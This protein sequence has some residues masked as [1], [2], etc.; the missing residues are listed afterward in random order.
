[1]LVTIAACAA[2]PRPPP[3]PPRKTHLGLDVAS[4]ALSNGLR[5]VLVHDPAA[6]DVH[7]TMRYAVGAAEE[8][9]ERAGIAHLVEHL[10]F[11]QVLG[12]RSIFA[13]L[14]D[15][16]TVFNA[17]TTFDATTYVT[18]A[19]AE[20]LGELLT[21]EAVRL[22]LRCTSIT[23][24]A[25]EREREVVIN[26][27]RQ[28][29]PASG[30]LE[31]VH[32]GV[33]LPG[34]P[35]RNPIE[36]EASLRAITRAEACAFAD[37][38]YGT[39][40]AVLVISSSAEPAALQAP[41]LKAF[42]HVAAREVTAQEAVPAPGPRRS[43]EVDAPIDE[44][45]I[46]LS[47]PMPADPGTQ[48]QLRA[49]V[50]L[51]AGELGD[52]LRGD[53]AAVVLGDVRSPRI[54]VVVAPG[55]GET[56]DVVGRSAQRALD[57]MTGLALL[58]RFALTRVLY[59]SVPQAAAY[60]L[61][62]SL[63]DA[64]S[65]DPLLAAFVLEGRDPETALGLQFRALNELTPQRAASLVHED[66]AYDRA[67]IVALRAVGKKRGRRTSFVPPIHDLGQR[68]EAPDPEVAHHPLA[69][70]RSP[71]PVQ[72]RRLPNGL[73]VVLVPSAAV[74]TVDIRL[75]LGVGSG[76]DRPDQRGLA[77]LAAS[78]LRWDDRYM[79]DRLLF[80]AAGGT[81]RLHI[82]RDRTTFEARGLDMH[83]DYLLA[84]L[85]RWVRD[86]RYTDASVARAHWRAS[87]GGDEDDV[88][89]IVRRRSS[90]YGHDHPYVA[91][92]LGV[93]TNP[94]L[95]KDDAER[96]REAHYTP[97]NATLVL[98]GHFDAALAD[99]WIDFLFADWHGHAV[100]RSSP[101][102]SATPAAFAIDDD[103]ELAS[104]DI[105]LPATAGNHAAQLVAAEMLA[106]ASADVRDQLGATY[107]LHADLDDAR[108]AR[109]YA[110]SGYVDAPRLREAIELLRARTEALRTDPVAAARAFVIARARVGTRLGAVRH[111]AAE[112]GAEIDH[113]VALG[114]LP[115]SD[116]ATQTE[117]E[118]LTV[119]ALAQVI[120]DLDLSR[121]IVTIRGPHAQVTDAFAVLARTPT[122]VVVPARKP[123][124]DPPGGDR[125]AE[126][127][128]PRGSADPAA[129]HQAGPFR[130]GR[131]E[132]HLPVGVRAR[133]RW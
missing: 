44:D 106:E 46:V 74:P 96:F 55:K 50:G 13:R 70:T 89:A 92:G 30:V 59:A 73:T 100:A 69:V 42:G 36:T 11:Q 90:L 113:D 29:D 23:D 21:I 88:S 48:I 103:V 28:R 15:I 10:M 83:V 17:T 53:V 82:G 54:A 124:T 66:L 14:E 117:V 51:V 47:W 78:A 8:P 107:G 119:D 7:V 97:D 52:D 109:D 9:H 121:A 84:G 127:R 130:G 114:R 76:D 3:A 26:E 33:F 75:E 1:M 91:A 125:R 45:A 34:H 102:A 80:G 2:A 37:R 61:Y 129:R 57:A 27:Q 32:R 118:A 5:V 22:D 98:T 25:F 49:L 64:A 120:A 126:L 56:F 111:R 71:E 104:L 131:P 108:L 41:V 65:R 133:A 35:Y 128:R 39:R 19:A 93:L 16:A 67:T 40:N 116:L 112:L 99:R 63:E 60:S 31:A 62:T 4:Y 87:L 77:S 132:R 122:M 38:Y 110:I 43:V 18:R 85:R 24:S 6:T 68:R 94:H 58:D 20:H 95:T 105:R 79:N 115:R 123:P 72:T 81:D 101:A 12:T 86:G